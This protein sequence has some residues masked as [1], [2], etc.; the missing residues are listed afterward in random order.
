VFSDNAICKLVNTADY[1]SGHVHI[2][3]WTENMYSK[4]GIWD[5]FYVSAYIV[6]YLKYK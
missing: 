2:N 1:Y 4:V 6:L 5:Y 3:G